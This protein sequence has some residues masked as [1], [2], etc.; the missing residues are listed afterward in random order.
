MFS[1]LRL[2]AKFGHQ[3]GYS[4]LVLVVLGILSELFEKFPL[5]LNPNVRP[6][7][8]FVILCAV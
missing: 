1:I 2:R 4:D 3:K 8:H 7:A 5:V 6:T